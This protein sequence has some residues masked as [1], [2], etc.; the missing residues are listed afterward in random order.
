VAPPSGAPPHPG[1]AFARASS[2]ILCFFHKLSSVYLLALRGSSKLSRTVSRVTTRQSQQ[3]TQPRLYKRVTPSGRMSKTGQI[4]VGPKL[5]VLTC[6]V[7]DYSAGGACLDIGPTVVPDRLEFL[8]GGVRKK[9]R[10]VWRRGIR[11]GLAF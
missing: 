4:I 3:M 8:Y 9:S 10:V 11:I 5:P 6:R 1:D 7:I 2:L